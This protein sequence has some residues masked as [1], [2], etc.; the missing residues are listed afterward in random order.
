MPSPRRIPL[1]L[2]AFILAL[3][4]LASAQRVIA[5]VP[6][7][8]N[9]WGMAVNPVTQK[10]YVVNQCGTG[11]CLDN[12]TVTVID[13]TTLATTTVSIGY[14]Q[15]EGITPIAVNQTTNKIYVAN[16]CGNHLYC[17]G[18][19]T[20]TVIDGATLSTTTVQVGAKP[21]ALAIN[22][23]TN[24]IYV[25]N[26]CG[27]DNDCGSNGTLTIIDGATLSTTSIPVQSS[28]Y[29]RIPSIAVNPVTNTIYVVNPCGNVPNCEGTPYNGTVMVIDGTTLASNTVTVERNP[30]C[31]AL[32]PV[33]NKIYVGN[34]DTNSVTVID[35]VTLST[36]N[37]L[38]PLT[39]V[40]LAVNSV[41][42]QTYVTTDVFNEN[43]GQLA[44][45]DGRTLATSF[46]PLSGSPNV[47]AVNTTTNKIYTSTY[48]FV[49]A[50]DGVNLSTLNIG[51]GPDSVDVA[52]DEATNR[53]YVENFDDNPG[54][55]TVIDGT[56]ATAW[57]FIPV[58]P[59]R[60]VDTRNPEGTFG[61][62]P[63]PGG[64]YRSFPIPQ[65]SCDIPSAAAAYS[66]NVTAVP[67]GPLSY[68]T[69]WPAGQP[70]PL[71]STM[72]S[73]DGR[74]KANAA[75]VAG[76]TN[77]AV[78]VFASNTT[79]VVL[80]INGYFVPLPNQNA[81]AFYPLT[82]CRVV[83]TRN[84]DGP[85]GGP[86]LQAGQE[87]DFPVL[88]ASACNIPDTAQA[89]SM[90]FTVI[91]QNILGYLTVWAS[92]QSKPVVSTL[93]DLTGTIVANAAIVPAGAG[94][95]I[96][97]YVTNNTNL[98]I[99]INGYFAP[100]GQNGLSLYA[101][102]VCRVFDTRVDGEPFQG[103]Y[104]NPIGVVSAGCTTSSLAQAFVLNAT[105]IP[106]GELGYL[107]LW[108]DGEP[109]PLASTL[110]APDGAITSN[111]AIVPNVDGSVDA[112]AFTS[113]YTQ[114]VLDTS[115]YFAP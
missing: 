25:V 91:P 108:P 81:L 15:G 60:V 109:Q 114:L 10:V 101:P 27:N 38:L 77:A 70:Q 6:V 55:V 14:A 28:T 13:E 106:S 17:T 113:N 4:S 2:S 89:Y 71:A 93:N 74:I 11:S 51:T 87:R 47:V 103:K 58:T 26:A 24:K 92:G 59:C 86:Y 104:V 54:T 31:I 63:I 95:D 99:D 29:D 90:N 33:T 96:N 61:G 22:E 112:F 3:T 12:G 64:T 72:N 100:P 16:V 94:G 41:T 18:L 39:P 67:H 98:V 46:V 53:I 78:S 73:L 85:L 68:L 110:N 75:I 36:T 48:D 50:I 35:G 40:S 102:T 56:P 57:Q 1:V 105:V 111:M 45:I 80:D 37:V 97:A 32:N 19:G 21:E 65:G 9:P 88:Q 79:D 62:P 115:G 23:V 82:P 107:T 44:A 5:T 84:S 76:G 7:G 8:Y 69:I 34:A 66:L 49:T 20:V 42:N 30:E 52:V 83:D 43:G